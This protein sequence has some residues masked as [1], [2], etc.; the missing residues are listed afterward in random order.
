MSRK[1]FKHLEKLSRKAAR[2][3]YCFEHFGLES[4]ITDVA[5]PRW[6]GP[7]YR[8]ARTRIVIVMLNPGSGE[9]YKQEMNRKGLPILQG[10]RDGSVSLRELFRHQ[11]VAME[12]WGTPRGWY[13]EYYVD[14]LGLHIDEI[15]FANIAWCAVSG[16]KYPKKMLK[17]CWG[18]HTSDLMKLLDPHV[19]VLAGRAARSFEGA[20][21]EMLPDARVIRM[22]HHAHR[23]G[24]EATRREH[25]RVRRL[26]G[27]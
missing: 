17:E 6:V 11:R 18:R 13:L 16:N 21:Q 26:I 3:R 19:V 23:K 14:R 25:R 15:A 5:Q 10:F 8:N 4:P 20:I 24:R 1:E 12:N 9:G 22:L 27:N 7:D 2:C